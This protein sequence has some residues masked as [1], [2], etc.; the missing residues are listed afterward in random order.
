M[1]LDEIEYNDDDDDYHD[2][3][4]KTQKKETECHSLGSLDNVTFGLIDPAR[5]EMRSA[6]P[7]SKASHSF[8]REFTFVGSF[9]NR[10]N[11]GYDHRLPTRC[12]PQI[13][14][15]PVLSTD[16]SLALAPV[17]EKKKTC[18]TVFCSLPRVS[19]TF[20]ST[21]RSVQTRASR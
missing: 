20:A 10:T 6:P 17:S 3:H 1:S 11:D 2:D 19:R 18:V 13:F 4:G 12:H 9:K 15:S 8:R 5:L 14:I 16:S 21:F 7:P